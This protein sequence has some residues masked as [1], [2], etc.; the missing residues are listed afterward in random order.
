MNI[1]SVTNQRLLSKERGSNKFAFTLETV[2]F[3]CKKI[4]QLFI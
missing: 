3:Y 2:T 1:A 4:L